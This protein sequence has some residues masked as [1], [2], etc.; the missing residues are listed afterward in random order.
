MPYKEIFVNLIIKLTSSTPLEIG[1]NASIF[2]T[3]FRKKRENGK[4]TTLTN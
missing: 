2:I 1:A 3:L 4:R